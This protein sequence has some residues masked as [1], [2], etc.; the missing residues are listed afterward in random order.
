LFRQIFQQSTHII[1]HK[2]FS[3]ESRVVPWEQ[4]DGR[5]EGRK[6]GRTDMTKLIVTI[7]NSANA[8]KNY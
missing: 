8:R 6:D 3:I 1:F 5:K 4:T 7:Q 2:T